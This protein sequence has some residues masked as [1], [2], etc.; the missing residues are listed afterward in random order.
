MQRMDYKPYK[1]MSHIWYYVMMRVKYLFDWCEQLKFTCK[2]HAYA[3]VHNVHT[4]DETILQYINTFNINNNKF[5]TGFGK[6]CI[7][8]TSNFSS[9]V[10]HNM[11]LQWQIDVKLSGIVE[12][13]FLYHP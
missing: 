1:Y 12:P 3:V 7:V 9:L 6:T 2:Q 10:I 13:L 5:V 11:Y 8:H 4:R